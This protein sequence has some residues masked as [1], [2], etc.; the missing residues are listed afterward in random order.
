[1]GTDATLAAYGMPFA[2][3]RRKL[4]KLIA[5]EG[6]WSED[7]FVEA[8]R[9][10]VLGQPDSRGPAAA[11]PVVAATA[12]APATVARS[13]GSVL[14]ASGATASAGAASPPGPRPAAGAVPVLFTS[15]DPPLPIELRRLAVARR[16]L[17]R[18]GYQVPGGV[19]H[20]CPAGSPDQRALLAS[21]QDRSELCR[22]ACSSAN[23]LAPLPHTAASAASKDPAA[24][25]SAVRDATLW[26]PAQ[27]HRGGGVRLLRPPM[28]RVRRG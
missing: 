10:V 11:A 24:L 20:A 13:D 25:L 21:D 8:A 23:W 2:P 26:A 1:M 12:P 6:A 5:S 16:A 7:P 9:A 14:S 22:L 17:L 4:Q 19:L 18:A 15:A 27:P 28:S 3:H